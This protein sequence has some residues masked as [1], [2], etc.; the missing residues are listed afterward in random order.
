MERAVDDD[1]VR[2][3]LLYAAALGPSFY[4]STGSV[5]SGDLAVVATAPDVS[6]VVQAG[7][8]VVNEPGATPAEDGPCLRGDAVALVEGLSFRGPL[9][10]DLDDDDVWLV[11]GLAE[12]FDTAR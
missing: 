7:P 8:T 9:D 12:V 10:H 5:R 6:F 1:E 4:A 3:C 2:G 11:A